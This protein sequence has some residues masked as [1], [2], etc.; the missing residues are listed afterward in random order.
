MPGRHVNTPSPTRR[1][2]SLGRARRTLLLAAFAVYAIT[3]LP[4]LLNYGVFFDGLTYASIARNLAEGHGTFWR[5]YYTDFV[6]PVFYEHPP[7]GPYL[8]SFVFRLV[9]DAYFVEVAYGVCLGA[10][11]LLLMGRFWDA[12]ARGRGRGGAWLAILL[13]ASMP[14]VSWS[15]TSNMLENTLVVFVLLAA[16]GFVRA[17]TSTGWR[18]HVYAVLGTAAVV[19]GLL[20]KGPVALF[21]LAIPFLHWL[22]FRECPV[23]KPLRVYALAAVAG[24]AMALALFAPDPD[25]R[26]FVAHYYDKQLVRALS[27]QRGT[28]PRYLFLI[29]AAMESLVPWAIGLALGLWTR[30]GV[31]VTGDRVFAFLLALAAAGSL[32]LM[33][34]PNQMGWYVFPA[35]PFFGLA[36]AALGHRIGAAVEH[37]VATSSRVRRAVSGAALALL[38]VAVAGA[39]LGRHLVVK[40]KDFHHD[41]TVQRVELP[42]RQLVSAVPGDLSRDWALVANLQRSYR[43]SIV[44]TLGA[45][46]L[47]TTVEH[48]ADSLV[49]RRYQR[50]H[51]GHPARYVLHRLR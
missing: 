36:Y 34:S 44:D 23:G 27:G 26:A 30:T 14:T 40:A 10:V 48:A 32:P 21:P 19:L 51:P 2:D 17:M 38:C 12:V 35:L 7:L 42:P 24:G 15:F 4:R 47:I 33:V 18:S 1:D 22:V 9:G 31:R 28:T 37:A 45:P 39:A 16:L 13:F 20:V 6:Y 8:Q 43:A 29:K 50:I 46:Y 11:T 3:V 41:F 49:V 5:P 25:A